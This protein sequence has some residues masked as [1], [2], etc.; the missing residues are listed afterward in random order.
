MPEVA[1]APK[2]AP[3]RDIAPAKT[4]PKKVRKPASAEPP[5]PPAAEPNESADPAIPEPEVSSAPPVADDSNTT[6]FQDTPADDE[7]ASA[8]EKVADDVKPVKKKSKV[9]HNAANAP[10]GKGQFVTTKEACAMLREP[11]SDEGDKVGTTKANRKI[12]VENVDENWVKG[13]NKAGEAGFIKRDC[14]E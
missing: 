6:M 10:A 5:P 13:F 1:P 14:V 8:S 7:S 2:I 4:L 12:W 9:K 3:K 11:A